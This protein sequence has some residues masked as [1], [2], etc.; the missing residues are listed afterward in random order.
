[1]NGVN[2]IEKDKGRLLMRTFAFFM[3]LP[4]ADSRVI[5]HNKKMACLSVQTQISPNGIIAEDKYGMN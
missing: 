5:L 2:K 3:I 1:M 4:K